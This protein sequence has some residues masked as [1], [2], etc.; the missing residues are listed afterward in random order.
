MYQCIIIFGLIMTF[1]TLSAYVIA[2]I[3]FKPITTINGMKIVE[4]KENLPKTA[5]LGEKFWVRTSGTYRCTS[6]DPIT[7]VSE[8]EEEVEKIRELTNNMKRNR[9]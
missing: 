7:Y 8:W 2:Y 3:M 4:R 6:T 1:I 9:N 5:K